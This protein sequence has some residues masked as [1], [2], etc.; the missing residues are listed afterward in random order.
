M[1]MVAL[2]QFNPTVLD[3]D[4]SSTTAP[5]AGEEGRNTAG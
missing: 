1:R 2:Q 3:S 5:T 4:L